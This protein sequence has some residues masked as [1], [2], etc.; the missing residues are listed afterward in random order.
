MVLIG[1]Y[2]IYPG[3]PLGRIN[4][5]GIGQPWNAPPVAECLAMM[6][7]SDSQ[8]K[9]GHRCPKKEHTGLRA[10]AVSSENYLYSSIGGQ[11]QETFLSP[12]T[13]SMRPTGG[14]YLSL[15]RCRTGV[16]PTARLYGRFHK[17]LARS[18][19]VCGA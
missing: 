13:L 6:V 17:S 14:Q 9:F 4:M 5:G 2:A 16:Q 8:G 11:E 3:I 18:V 19:T 7:G 10:D 1:I 12:C 15:L